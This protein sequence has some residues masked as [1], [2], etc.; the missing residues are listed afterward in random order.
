[1]LRLYSIILTILSF[2]RV[3]VLGG[4]IEVLCGHHRT[5]PHKCTAVAMLQRTCCFHCG[6]KCRN[7][8]ELEYGTV[9]SL[10]RSRAL[11]TTNQCLTWACAARQTFVASVREGGGCHFCRKVKTSVLRKVNRS[12]LLFQHTRRSV[13]R[14]TK[15][16]FLQSTRLQREPSTLMHHSSRLATPPHP[17]I[18]L[19][20]VH[21]SDYR[22]R[23]F[24]VCNAV[25]HTAEPA[26]SN[27]NKP[28]AVQSI[29]T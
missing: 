22:L 23:T 6:G 2:V 11:G 14:R 3:P 9:V 25:L 19:N 5:A 28:L 12:L 24:F 15:S 8:I 1:M 4:T 26:L 27:Q 17:I 13:F 21:L 7:P 18:F 29:P 20:H 10:D 16:T